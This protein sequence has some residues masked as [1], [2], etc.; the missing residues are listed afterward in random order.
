MIIVNFDRGRSYFALT[1]YVKD[2]VENLKI[3]SGNEGKVVSGADE[4][5]NSTNL[6][7]K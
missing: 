7:I 6:W 4:T 2:F 1:Y 3:I 5:L